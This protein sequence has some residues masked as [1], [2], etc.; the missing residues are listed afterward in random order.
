MGLVTQ[1]GHFGPIGI[2]TLPVD[3]S[4][5]ESLHVVTARCPRT[6]TRTHGHTEG[7]NDRNQEREAL[8]TRQISWGFCC[9]GFEHPFLFC[10]EKDTI[11]VVTPCCFVGLLL[12]FFGL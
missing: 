6:D 9:T 10:G 5:E 4:G 2:V 12:V 3:R 7:R 1:C 11:V 8:C